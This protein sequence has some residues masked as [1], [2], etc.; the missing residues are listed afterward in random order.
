MAGDG[1]AKP[2]GILLYAGLGTGQ[3]LQYRLGGHTVLVR[4]LDL[5]TEWREIH[6]ALIGIVNEL[7]LT[8]RTAGLS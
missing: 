1:A 2:V 7:A 8:S 3:P 6:G 4:S 5:N